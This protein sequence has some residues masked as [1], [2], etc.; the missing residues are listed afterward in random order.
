MTRTTHETSISAWAKPLD[1]TAHRTFAAQIM[2]E[3][4]AKVARLHHLHLA[5]GLPTYET[6][7]FLLPS[8]TKAY[9]AYCRKVTRTGVW[10]LALRYSLPDAHTA[11]HRLLGATLPDALAA[12]LSL[13]RSAPCRV[14]VTPYREPEQSGTFVARPGLAYLEYIRGPHFWLTKPHP[15]DVSLLSCQYCFPSRSIAY[16]TADLLDRSL[17]F[18]RFRYCVQALMGCTIRK[19]EARNQCVYAEFHWHRETGPIFIECSF[20]DVWAGLSSAGPTRERRCPNESND[21]IFHG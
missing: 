10:L 19:I 13:A 7:Q 20:A 9:E 11:I 2:R 17:L 16:S 8:Q 6:R 21:I 3:E 5:I 18:Q 4:E 12:G 15:A 1:H 14:A